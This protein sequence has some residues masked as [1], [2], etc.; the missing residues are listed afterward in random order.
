MRRR[1]SPVRGPWSAV[2]GPRS[3]VRSPW[4]AGSHLLSLVSGSRAR[5]RRYC[6]APVPL[7]LQPQAAELVPLGR[8]SITRKR[9]ERRMRSNLEGRN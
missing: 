5:T 9:F 7:Q 6:L 8:Q 1:R 2:L 4:S 3:L